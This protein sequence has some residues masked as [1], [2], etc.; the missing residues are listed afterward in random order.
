MTILEAIGL[1]ALQGVTEFLPVSSS[2]HLVIGQ[3]L[4][5]I[6]LPGNAFEIWVHLGTLLS[7]VFVFN[8]EIINMLTSIGNPETRKYIG[9]LITGTIPAVFVGFGFKET[10][11]EFFDSVHIVSLGLMITASVLFLT[12]M[13]RKRSVQITLLSGLVIG[14][15][16]ALAIVPG[17][18]RSGTT[19]AMALVLGASSKDAAKFSFFKTS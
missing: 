3:H 8:K 15:A 9:I 6:T 18:S 10:I 12:G 16:Q 17:I 14:M 1:G 19:I 7:I 11:S 13:I 4:L 5:G 2:G